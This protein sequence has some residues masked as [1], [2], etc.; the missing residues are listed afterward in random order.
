MTISRR[1]A[2]ARGKRC[3]QSMLLVFA[4]ASLS[5]QKSE[6]IVNLK[7]SQKTQKNGVEGLNLESGA[8]N[9]YIGTTATHERE[10]YDQGYHRFSEEF[11]SN[12]K[13]IRLAEKLT[14]KLRKAQEKTG[15]PW[16]SQYAPGPNRR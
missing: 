12:K 2:N 11:S 8:R 15:I 7:I 6:E 10:E 14:R 5:S 13:N 4:I 3:A 16:T 1:K 9:D